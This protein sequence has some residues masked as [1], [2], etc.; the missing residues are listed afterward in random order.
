M[1]NDQLR[2]QRNSYRGH[3]IP[4]ITIDIRQLCVSYVIDSSSAQKEYANLQK[5]RYINT[6]K[7]YLLKVMKITMR[8]N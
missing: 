2:K 6:T 3:K 5:I 7:D 1:F 4:K 8:P